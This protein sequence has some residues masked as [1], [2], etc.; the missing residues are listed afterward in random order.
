MI[1][2]LLGVN[3]KSGKNRKSWGFPPAAIVKAPKLGQ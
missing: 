1:G 2:N 3:W